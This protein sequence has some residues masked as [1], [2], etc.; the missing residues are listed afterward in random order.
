MC[1]VNEIFYADYWYKPIKPIPSYMAKFGP[2]INYSVSLIN[3]FF[4]L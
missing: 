3:V 4:K 2:Q 1:F